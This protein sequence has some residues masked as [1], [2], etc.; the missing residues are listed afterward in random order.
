MFAILYELD[1]CSLLDRWIAV[2]DEA[3]K[4]GARLPSPEAEARLACSMFI[5][6]TLRQ[7]Q[8]RD[9]KQW[10]E[11]ALKASAG[12][13]DVNL[14]MF[15]G[16]LAS[17]TLMWT[18]LYSRALQLIEAMRREAQA[19]GVT[20]FSLITL[21]NI[22]TMYAA[23]RRGR[24]AKGGARKASSWCSYLVRRTFQRCGGDGGAARTNDLARVALWR[25]TRAR[26]ATQAYSTCALP[27]S[28]RG[29]MLR[30][31]D[32]SLRREQ[33]RSALAKR[34]LLPSVSKRCAPG[35][36]HDPARLRGRAQMLGHPATMRQMCAAPTNPPLV[37]CLVGFA[38][39]ARPRGQ[40]RLHAAAARP[41]ALPPHC[42]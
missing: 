25:S 18:G 6:L 29:A 32:V 15:V 9:I 17:L 22:E 20:P 5:S 36:A 41:R 8:R 7:P 26:C 40:D 12:V 38:Q 4:S 3:Q 14:R 11:R 21:K 30:K 23:D 16:L 24:R 28:R 1:D 27:H 37:T 2:L 33:E 42:Y 35:A 39:I 13:P 19:S 34:F 10:I 31:D